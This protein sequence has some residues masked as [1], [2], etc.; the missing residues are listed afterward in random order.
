M[1]A[2]NGSDTVTQILTGLGIVILLYVI[3]AVMEFIYKSFIGMW[4]DRVE[5]FPDTYVSGSKMY[6]AIQNPSNPEAKTVYF[7]DNQRSGVEFSYSMFLNINSETFASG[8]RELRH[9][10]HKG[11]SQAYPLMGPGIFCWGDKN[12]LRVFMNCYNTWDNWTDIDNIPVDKWF[13]LVV[14]CKGN[15]IY[16]YINGNLKSKVTLDG[17][18]PAYQNYGNIYAFSSR[19]IVLNKANTPSLLN[20]REATAPGS[21]FMGLTFNGS[22]KGMISRVFYFSYALTYSEI[23][24]LMKMGPSSN[25]IGSSST[26]L[27]APYLADTWWTA[28]Q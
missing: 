27:Q 7:S 12:T 23:Q 24:N 19:K 10:L 5:L 2:M 16:I 9:I 22:A 4:K 1:E 13:H 26:S 25:I 20:D 6:T 21:Q 11:Y 14:S 18:T 28:G 8:A 3:M 15:K 17:N